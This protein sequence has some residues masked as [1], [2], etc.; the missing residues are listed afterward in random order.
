[1]AS[2][3]SA[4]GSSRRRDPPS[5]TTTKENAM[6]TGTTT[7]TS[8]IPGAEARTLEVPGATLTYD[9]RRSEATNEPPLV[10]IGSPMGAGGFAPLARHFPDRTI[11]SYD[12][13]GN[14][15]RSKGHDPS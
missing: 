13:R 4:T 6:T 9:V 11:V 3:T 8:P 10:L 12:P 2:S 7:V 14:G 15:E 1:M 5:S